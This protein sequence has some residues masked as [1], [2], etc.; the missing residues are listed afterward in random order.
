MDVLTLTPTAAWRRPP[1][2]KS[3]WLPFGERAK[4]PI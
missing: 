2:A 4:K 1:T 3:L